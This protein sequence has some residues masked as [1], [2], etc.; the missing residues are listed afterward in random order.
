[1]ICK[2]KSNRVVEESVFKWKA[3]CAN[4]LRTGL[5]VRAG[6]LGQ[7]RWRKGRNRALSVF[8]LVN[9]CSN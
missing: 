7:V 9:G 2:R 4:A 6:T 5:H 3:R 8:R 1:M